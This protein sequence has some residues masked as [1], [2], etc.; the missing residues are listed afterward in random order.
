MIYID[1]THIIVIMVRKLFKVGQKFLIWGK[2][3][4]TRPIIFLTFTR[5]SHQ[6]LLTLDRIP[7]VFFAPKCLIFVLISHAGLK[8]VHTPFHFSSNFVPERKSLMK[9]QVY[10]V[11]N[12]FNIGWTVCRL[13]IIIMLDWFTGN[14]LK[15]SVLKILTLDQSSS[16]WWRFKT[17]ISKSGTLK[18]IFPILENT[19]FLGDLLSSGNC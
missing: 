6:C 11:N 14:D 4:E 18:G 2:T 13:N 1:W 7:N 5:K 10:E 9:I 3:S 19:K 8:T 15:F 12:H 16:L 17:L